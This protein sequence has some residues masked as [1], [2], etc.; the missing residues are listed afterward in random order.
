MSVIKAGSPVA[1]SNRPMIPTAPPAATEEATNGNPV[2]PEPSDLVTLFLS[3]DVMVGRG[4]DQILPHP[5]G[6]RIYEPHVTAATDYVALA[7]MANGPI[8]KP[9]A[10]RYVWGDALFEFERRRPDA[11]IVNL[12]TAVTKS[13]RPAPKGINYRVSPENIGVISVAGIDCCVLANNHVLDWGQPG[14]LETLT[15]L[16]NGDIKYVGAGHNAIEAA[17]P[18]ILPIQDKGRVLVYALGSVDSGIPNEWAATES[19]PG[20]NLLPDLSPQTAHRIAANIRA[21]RQSRDIVVVSIHWG[22]NWGYAVPDEHVAFAH[23]LV[24]EG[25][26]DVVHGHSSHHAKAIEIYRGRLILYGCGDFVND[27]EG[28]AGHKAYRG[29]LALMYL[30]TVHASSGILAGLTMVP[31]QIRNF[32]LNRVSRADAEWLSQTLGTEGRRFGT[33]VCLG[34]EDALAL[35]WD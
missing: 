10:F 28:I 4:I 25:G 13:D 34:T 20:I 9:A 27:Y 11:R 8:R 5:V 30:P 17:M 6:P 15:T 18:A 35:A 21:R 16:Q 32:R 24:D 33:W 29:D 14:L 7:Q 1:F 12:E 2:R 22:P 23:R 31:F 26:A 19:Q 3:G